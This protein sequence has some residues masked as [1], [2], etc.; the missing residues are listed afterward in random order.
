MQALKFAGGKLAPRK[1]RE[2][3]IKYLPSWFFSG[4]EIFFCLFW[5][6]MRGFCGPGVCFGLA[7]GEEVV[8]DH[9]AEDDYDDGEEAVGDE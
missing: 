2:Q 4:G 6:E 8:A 7:G 1:E 9:E 3:I 5:Q